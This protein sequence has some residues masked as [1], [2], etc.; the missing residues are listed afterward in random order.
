[1]NQDREFN[2][3]GWL[4]TQFFIGLPMVA[5]GYL[6][7]TF[8]VSLLKKRPYK[9]FAGS[10]SFLELSPA[11]REIRNGSAGWQALYIIYNWYGHFG[12]KPTGLSR[13]PL[14]WLWIKI[15]NAQAV[16]N[17]LRI[18]VRELKEAIRKISSLGGEEIRIASIASGSAQSLFLAAKALREEGFHR[19]IRILLVDLDQSALEKSLELADH[20]DF[21]REDII[22]VKASTSSIERI[23]KRNEFHPHIIEMAGFLDYCQDRKAIFLIKTIHRLLIPGGFFFTCHI[24]PNFERHF[25]RW[26]LCWSML[27]RSRQDFLGLIEKSGDWDTTAITEPHGI[28]TVAVCRKKKTENK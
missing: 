28:H 12:L 11:C 22:S 3:I 25:L 18:I 20:F 5:W 9:K 10:L 4:L 21:P 26:V 15:R 27:Y 2:R 23:L 6:V 7:W 14:A 19:R 13:D 17:R 1:M 24:H 8:N 16:R